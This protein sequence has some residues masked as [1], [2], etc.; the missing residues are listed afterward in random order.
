MVLRLFGADALETHVL[1]KVWIEVIKLKAISA[2]EVLYSRQNLLSTVIHVRIIVV[3]LNKKIHVRKEFNE[4]LSKFISLEKCQNHPSQSSLLAKLQFV[5]IFLTF[6]VC[7]Y[8]FY[9]LQF[10]TEFF[11]DVVPMVNIL[12][13][14]GSK[15]I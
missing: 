13:C 12:F 3:V 10:L 8:E 6:V 9:C 11:S 5:D 2:F 15:F 4:N 7:L 14:H 1:F